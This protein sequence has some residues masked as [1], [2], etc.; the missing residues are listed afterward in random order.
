ME[1]DP[2]RVIEG[3]I[4]AGYRRPG[5]SR[6]IFMS[7]PNIPLAVERLRIAIDQARQRTAFWEQTSWIPA[8]DFDIHISQGAGAFVCGEGSALTASI[9]GNRGMPRVKPPRTVEHG[10][11]DKSHGPKQ[12]GDLLPT[13]PTII[14]KGADW[15]QTI[16]PENNHGHQGLRPYRKRQQYRTHRGSHGYASPEG[17]LRHRRRRQGRRNSRLYRSA[18]PPEAVSASAPPRTIWICTWTSTP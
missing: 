1:G 12:R 16:G 4:I 18:A 13:W 17:H 7:A 14:Q 5:P 10:L 8:L 6:D 3:M 9:E 15:Y 11:F 2:H